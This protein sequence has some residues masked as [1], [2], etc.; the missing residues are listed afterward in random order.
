[1]KSHITGIFLSLCAA[2]GFAVTPPSIIPLP[3][4]MEV[5]EG[6]MPLSSK[7]VIHTAKSGAGAAELLAA[8]LRT[9]TGLPIKVDEDTSARSGIVLLTTKTPDASLGTEGYTLSII[10]DQAVI[11]ASSDAGLFYGTQTLL[12][13]LP[14]E[15]FS[16]KKAGGVKWGIPCVSITDSPRFGWRGL[17]VDVSRHFLAVDE[18][19]KF[20]DVMAVHKLN[21]MH[22]HLT[23]D[24]GWRLEIK[25][26]PL[27]TK[28]G[29]IRK[30]SPMPGNRKVGDGTPYGPFFYTQKQ[31]R[32]LVAYAQARHITIVP[33]IEMPGHLLGVL[34]AYPEYS[35]TGGPFQVRTKWGVEADVLCIGNT[36]S[37]AL[38]QDILT[39]VLDLFP[40]KFIHIGGDEVPRDRWKK[41]EKCQALMK[42]E[43]LTKEAQLQT[44]FNHHIETFLASKGRRLIGWDEI[45]EG[46]LTP[47][48]AVM[49]WRGIKG[50]IEAAEQGHDVVMS[51]NS[52]LYLDHAQAKAPGEPE[53]IGGYSP[54]D[55]V[56]SYEPVPAELPADKQKHV[57]G[58]QGNLWSE[59]YYDPTLKKIEYQAYPRACALAE[60]AWS[61]KEARNFDGFYKRLPAHLKRLEALNVNFRRLDGATL[62]PEP[63]PKQ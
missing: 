62:T 20:L 50:G 40:S 28:L 44:W 45:L 52:H 31:I 13:L 24:Q 26:Y 59:Y 39:E 25:K 17:L 16:A 10:R 7:T 49:S 51:P 43:G 48:A 60:L 29:S 6:V 55:K 41:C 61:P 18:L 35:C 11:T 27:L 46:G 15:V 33:E 5:K 38:M 56:Y 57:L 4:N 14:P 22:L 9:A 8:R 36:N 30:E 58:T 32:D 12:Q 23:D 3:Q 54:L 1:M 21:T 47:G 37:V 19:K 34:T 42:A 2:T 53:V 63:K